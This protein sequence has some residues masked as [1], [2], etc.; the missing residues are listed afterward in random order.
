MFLRES[1]ICH[2]G[3]AI[4][5]TLFLSGCGNTITERGRSD[6]GTLATGLLNSFSVP[7]QTPPPRDIRSIQL[8]RSGSPSYPPILTLGEEERL[9]LEFDRIGSDARQ[10]QVLI[11]HYSSDWEPS[12]L[13]YEF[14]MSGFF[15]DYFGSGLT[16]IAGEPSY[17]HYRYEL[18]NSRLSLT[19]S[20]N[21]LLSV[22][23]PGMNGL[24]FS[25]PFF[26][27]EDEGSIQSRVE[28][29]LT[30]RGEGDQL[31]SEYLYPEF[32]EFPGFDLS[33]YYIQN[34]FWG[35]ARAVRQW[36]TSSPD[37]VHFHL[38][39][40]DVFAGNYEF[41]LLDLRSFI[42]TGDPILS[43]EPEQTPPRI[44][45]RRDLPNFPPPPAIQPD[46]RF[47]LPQDNRD[48]RY[49]DVLFRLEAGPGQIDSSAQ[50]HLVGDF[51][52]WTPDPLNR[53]HFNPSSGYWEVNVIIKQGEY[54]YKYIAI[55]NGRIDDR[56]FDRQFTIR[57]QRYTVLVY[58]RDPSRN[59]DRL[60]KVEEFSF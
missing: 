24:L 56:I 28:T 26:V 20:G 12:P 25:I 58:F 50:I 45:L 49:A 47:G 39:R 60:L 11:Q 27:S 23:D 17:R 35:G 52:H 36:D 3:S 2:K 14:Y 15:T 18:P 29:I 19:A 9:V 43:F 33:Y 34:H 6:T 46:T 42:A 51:N 40:D 37:A 7:V 57:R 59:Y 53:L 30:E 54:A 16:S 31:F 21:Y 38:E 32:V 8:Y 48:A 22:H 1:T 5:L 55:E 13:P 4:L 44:I 41:R 10:F